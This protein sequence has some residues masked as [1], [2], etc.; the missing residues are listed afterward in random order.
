MLPFF[1]QLVPFYISNYF[2][3]TGAFKRKNNMQM[4]NKQAVNATC[5]VD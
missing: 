5:V 2:Q 3:Q 4:K 1:C